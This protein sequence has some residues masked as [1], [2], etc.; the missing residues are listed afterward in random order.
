MELPESVETELKEI[1]GEYTLAN[2]ST[3]FDYTKAKQN[4][5]YVLSSRC[6]YSEEIKKETGDLDFL[7]E[8]S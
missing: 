8:F 3:H 2:G 6:T 7:T 5:L 1:L 4:I